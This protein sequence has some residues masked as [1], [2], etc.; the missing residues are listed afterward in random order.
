MK[1]KQ[2]N[3]QIKQNKRQTKI[4]VQKKRREREKQRK[5]NLRGTETK[6]DNNKRAK[7]KKR[8]KEKS[9]SRYYIEKKMIKRP[10]L[11]IT[12]ELTYEQE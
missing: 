12:T 9:A 4:R 11:L 7:Q 8:K 3:K 2:T 5:Q 6:T 1:Q 10:M